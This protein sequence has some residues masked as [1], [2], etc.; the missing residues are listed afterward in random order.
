VLERPDQPFDARRVGIEVRDCR[1]PSARGVTTGEVRAHAGR[2]LALIRLINGETQFVPMEYLEIIPRHESRL[3]AFA[4]QRTGGPRELAR[5][6]LAEKISGRLT[7]VYYSM[8]SGKADFFPHQF[9]PVLQFVESTVGRILVADEVGLGKTISAIYIWREL[10]ARTGARRL[11]IICPAVLRDK[12]KLELRNRFSIE[13]QIVDAATLEEHLENSRRDGLKAYTLIG[14]L[15]GLRSR[16]R[17]QEGQARAP[18]QRL[19][20]WLQDNPA[21]SE[22]APIDLVIIDEAHAARNPNTANHHFC[23]ALRESSAHLVLLTATPVQTH[24]ENLFNLLKLVDPERF[25]TADTFEQARRAN[26]SIIGAVNALLRLPPDRDA[27][28]RNVESAANEPLFRRDTF[29]GNLARGDGISW[30]HLHRVRLARML[31]S[32]SLLADV[33]VRTRKRE[34]F[35]DRVQ[36]APWVLNVTLTP[37]ERDLYRQLSARVRA[38]ARQNHA[39]TPTEFILIGR[40]RQLASSIPAT[41]RVWNQTGHLD[42]LLWEDLGLDV[43]TDA[44]KE[45][46]VPIQDL[47]KDHDF[48][49]GDSKYN[50][51][52]Q[53]IRDHLK[54]HPHEKIVVFAFFRGTLAYLQRRLEADGVRC[55]CIYGSMGMRNTDDGEMDAKTAEIARFAE[56]DG[57]S[58]L[59]SSEVGSEGI[60]LQFARMVFNYDLPWNPM[61]VEQRI[62]RIDRMGQSAKRITIGHFVTTGTVDDRIINRLYQRI[63]VFKESIGDLDE[64]FG[65]RIQDVILDYFR[66]N[67]SPEETEQRIEQNAL[68]IENN[69]LETERLEKE[70]PGL[71]GHAEYILRSIRQSHAAGHY[72]RPEDLRRYVTDFLHERFPGSSVEYQA[73]SADIVRILPSPSARDALGTFIEQERPARQTRLVDPSANVLVTFNPNAPTPVRGRP[74]VVDVTHPLV[75]WMRNVTAAES[76]EIVPAV[77]A[78]IDKA[79][80]G[81]EPGVY[82]FASD[83]WRLEGV[84]KQITLQHVVLSVETGGRLDAAQADRLVDAVAQLGR[85][86]DLFEFRSVYDTLTR[87]FRRCDEMIQADYLEE[88]VAFES[89]NEVRVAQARQLVEARAAR[90]LERLRAILDQ[91][92]ISDDERRRRVIPLTEARIRQVVEDQNKQLA[93]IER[94][95]R[96]DQSFRSIVGGL[97][98]VRSQSR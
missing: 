92:R 74:E 81:V 59:L 79:D 6:L 39:D 49:A 69:K 97:I 75:L 34:A 2:E 63:N 45:P 86:L 10:Q 26:I 46:I 33:M 72:I 36:R 4:V 38:L 58:V 50:A 7:D 16:R 35:E 30:D 15:E 76:R 43:E 62:G 5:H 40:Q 13:A 42:E 77:A 66:E 80:V 41:L 31:E 67:L 48:E 9:R 71:A 90:K 93:R 70:A 25:V 44:D 60:D 96:V 65:E 17:I 52:S 24:S 19:M 95:G 98:V 23:D 29:L 64:I 8:G 87:A 12:W 57:P 20:Q 91:Q 22:F 53:A 28:Q 11:L 32:R 37:E 54:Q 61:R 84:R 3:D 68:A 18:R 85:S 83:F 27:F 55:A 1:N 78:E 51:F 73:G 47:L 21:T 56:R 88:L 94:Q 82:V 89:D 14:S